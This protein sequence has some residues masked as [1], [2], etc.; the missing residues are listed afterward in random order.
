METLFD[1]KTLFA[2]G[3]LVAVFVIIRLVRGPLPPKPKEE[4]KEEE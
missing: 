3:A 4:P 1:V 2:L